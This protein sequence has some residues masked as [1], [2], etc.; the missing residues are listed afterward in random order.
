M[1]GWCDD[2]LTPQPL[3]AIR[4]LAPGEPSLAAAL[5]GG[6]RREVMEGILELLSRRLR[7]TV[8]VLEDVQWADEATLDLIR[9]VGRRIGLAH[10]LLVLTYRDGEVDRDHPLCGVMGDIPAEHVV[11]IGLAPL[12][13]AGVTALVEGAGLD[14]AE[15]MALTAGNPLFVTQ[16]AAWGREEVPAS[17]RDVVLARLGRLAAEVRGVLEGLSVLPGGAA[18]A[19]LEQIAGR[20]G[21]EI[22]VGVQRGLLQLEGQVVRFRHEVVRRA[23][24]SS[25]SPETRRRLNR[26]VLEAMGDGADPARLL[27][28][29]REAGDAAAIVA[30]APRASGRR[31][32]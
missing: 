26:Q 5:S 19:L 13:A 12:S 7:P 25:L 23:V 15:V 8:V 29:A 21:E 18:P 16:V 3:G 11:R 6:S 31:W 10:G 30:Y 17:V 20:S 24:E 4:D 9:F 28:H 1:L 22:A 2:P 14:A 32:R 27:H